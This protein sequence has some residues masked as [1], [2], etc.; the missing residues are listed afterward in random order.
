MILSGTTCI[1][2]VSAGFYR[3]T[4]F[5]CAACPTNCARCADT[6]GICTACNTGFSLPSPNTSPTACVCDTTGNAMVLITT[7]TPNTCVAATVCAAGNYNIGGSVTNPNTC[8]KCPTSNCQTCTFGTGACT[9][10]NNTFV[11]NGAVATTAVNYCICAS[12]Q[13]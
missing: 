10:C 13:Y 4:S 5:T 11:F 8:A 9:A 6:T 2:P 7:V 3:T 12:T 1:C